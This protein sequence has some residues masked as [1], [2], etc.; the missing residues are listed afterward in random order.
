MEFSPFCIYL[1]RMLSVR[2]REI[3]DFTQM[4]SAPNVFYQIAMGQRAPTQDDFN[5]LAAF[6]DVSIDHMMA[7]Y[8]GQEAP[9]ITDTVLNRGRA[10]GG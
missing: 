6:L 4:F 5:A 1:I 10:G 2:A 3:N 9:Q 7:V 8:N